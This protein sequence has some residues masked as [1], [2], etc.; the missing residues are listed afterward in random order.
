MGQVWIGID[1]GLSGAVGIASS[2]F[3][4][5]T[6]YEVVDVPTLAITVG[7]HTRRDYVIPG[8]LNLLR[9]LSESVDEVQVGIEKVHAHPGQGVSSSFSF[10]RGYGLWLMAIVALKIPY[11]EIT[12]QAWKK[13]M[14]AGMT[15]DKDAARLRAAQLFPLL[16]FSKKSDDGRAEALLIAEF[17]RRRLHV[18][19]LADSKA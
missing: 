6:T 11:T 12:P 17:T 19:S 4:G 18:D 8:M 16:D 9:E 1:P 15:K 5:R 10:G 3:V 7:K 13:E 2:G 14:M